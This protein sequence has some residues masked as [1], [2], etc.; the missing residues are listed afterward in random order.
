MASPARARSVVII[1]FAVCWLTACGGQSPL[2]PTSSSSST[3]SPPPVAPRCSTAT[4]GAI[5]LR[6]NHA[7]ASFDIN[8]SGGPGLIQ[9]RLDLEV[10][11]AEWPALDMTVQK[12]EQWALG[13]DG[14]EYGHSIVERSERIGCSTGRISYTW[15]MSVPE[16]EFTARPAARTYRARIEYTYDTSPASVYV[17]TAEKEIESNIP[18]PLMTSLT[19]TA[20]APV[21]PTSIPARPITFVATGTGGIPPYEYQ[22]AQGYTFVLRDWSPDARFIWDPSQQPPS[23]GTVSITAFAR[24]AGRRDAEVVKTMQFSVK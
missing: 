7:S 10:R 5:T 14:S 12:L 6:L 8:K 24:S 9:Y 3:P 15:F 11:A 13:A 18:S 2:Q 21:F 17:V 20:D 19:M 22:Y 23:S 1:M 16:H 4:G